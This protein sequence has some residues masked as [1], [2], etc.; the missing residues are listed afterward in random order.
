MWLLHSRSWEMKE[1]I[2]HKQAPPYAILSHT[3]GNEEVSFKDWESQQWTKFETK[4]GFRKIKSFC[5]Q[6]AAQG[7]EWV[8]VDTCCIDKRSSA[9]L[10]EAINSMFNWYKSADV[11]YVYLYDVEDDIKS[12]L[13]GSR[14]ITRGWTLQELIAPREVVFYSCNWRILGT[15]SELSAHLA[16]VTR[17]DE[18]FLM[19]ESLDKASIAQRMSWAAARST[20][21]EEDEAYC[22][23]GL[24]NVNM[25]LIYG[26]GPK[27]FRRLQETL[28]REYPE[29]HSLFAWGRIVNRLS[30]QLEDSAA[31]RSPEP[32]DI[33]H[34]PSEV[35]SELL[36]LLARSPNDFEHSGQVVSAPTAREYFRLGPLA[37]SVS[38][39]AG[40]TAHVE[41]PLYNGIYIAYHLPHIPIGEQF[42]R[43]FH[44]QELYL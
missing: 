11:C 43:S 24:F 32:V 38:V 36:G 9:E 23:L 27:A 3:W 7:F 2:S 4:E 12:T 25:S 44:G 20:T 14:W 28:A 6:A 26:E 30:N 29:D 5:E 17:I 35:G 37:L 15:R 42:H 39:M 21:R 16:T 1:F 34:R 31:L 41:L 13:A 19:G 40:G 22:L 10:S 18:Q 8:W 33:K